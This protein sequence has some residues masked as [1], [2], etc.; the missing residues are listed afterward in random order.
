MKTEINHNRKKDKKK[1]KEI[2]AP[3]NPASAVQ[4]Q[5]Q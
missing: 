1:K 4:Q 2:T 3:I 5:Q